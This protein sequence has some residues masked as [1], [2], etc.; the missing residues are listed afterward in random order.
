MR[1]ARRRGH[2]VP[3][4]TARDPLPAQPAACLSARCSSYGESGQSRPRRHRGRRPWRR[5][6]SRPGFGKGSARSPRRHRRRELRADVGADAAV[7]RPWA[8]PPQAAR[9]RVMDRQLPIEVARPRRAR[10][11][12][13]CMPRSAARRSSAAAERA[14]RVDGSGRRGLGGSR[15]PHRAR[16]TLGSAAP[17]RARPAPTARAPADRR[18]VSARCASRLPRSSRAGVADRSRARSGIVAARCAASRSRSAG[19]RS[20]VSCPR[21]ERRRPSPQFRRAL[22]PCA[23][24][25]WAAA[26][27]AAQAPYPRVVL[28]YYQA[29]A[30]ATMPCNRA[31]RRQ[32]RSRTHARSTAMLARCLDQVS[33]AR[34]GASERPRAR[35]RPPLCARARGIDDFEAA[36]NPSARARCFRHFVGGAVL[37][38]T[39]SAVAQPVERTWRPSLRD[40]ADLGVAE[41]P[42]TSP[43]RPSPWTGGRAAIAAGLV[44]P[45][46]ASIV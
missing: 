4:A 30:M 29:Y 5:L 38:M 9:A 1:P 12:G 35:T 8:A 16:P 34:V 44:R 15:A 22:V 17:S 2:R 33:R 39:A 43:T 27:R 31:R 28:A 19:A 3:P 20:S 11:R 26:R 41:A 40:G 21:G 24:T 45:L 10:P 42:T 14:S 23:A 18:C 25:C 36:F 32:L 37:H 6:R 7:S 13:R 46:F